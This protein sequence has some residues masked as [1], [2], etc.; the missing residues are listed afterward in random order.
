MTYTYYNKKSGRAGAFFCL[1][2]SLVMTI[3]ALAAPMQAAA[4][5]AQPAAIDGSAAILV[6][7]RTGTVLY[8][9]NADSQIVPASTT[10]VMT[11]LLVVEAIQRGEIALT[12]LVA[13]TDEIM[14]DVPSDA[15]RIGNA[16]VVGEQVP[17]RDLLYMALMESDCVACDMLAVHVS[18]SVQAFVDQM[19]VRASQL[20]CANTNFL[21][22]HGYPKEG[23]TSTAR[24][25]YL[26]TAEAVKYPLF[27]E[28]FGCLKYVVP[29][30]NMAASRTIYSTDKLLYDP[31]VVTSMYTVYYNEYVTGG[32]TGYSTASGNCLVS[33]AEKDGLQL[34][35]V[36]TGVKMK[37]PDEQT[38]IDAF[39]ESDRLIRWGLENYSSYRAVAAGEPVKNVIEVEKGTPQ[40]IS[41]VCSDNI[42]VTLEKGEPA[43]SVQVTSTLVG[44]V[45]QAPVSSGDVIGSVS[46]MKNGKTLAS[47]DLVAGGD[48]AIAPKVFK[49]NVPL[50]LILSMI[51]AA[52]A[53]FLVYYTNRNE[54]LLVD[55]A[56]EK[57]GLSNG[58][59]T[60]GSTPRRVQK[61]APRPVEEEAENDPYAGLFSGMDYDE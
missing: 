46:V 61:P 17:V 13:L 43:E 26:I 19:N 48:S 51:V 28:A 35:S 12:D 2:L 30:T 40:T 47:A 3:C 38:V 42:Y 15:S 1:L 52:G 36:I 60:S 10:K 23:H 32:K 14:H 5:V 39:T 56:K 41:G 50:I 54:L 53:A 7:A 9:Q 49:A 18:G 45:L 33:T 27:T 55:Y 11:A 29:E 21:N 8:E 58:T 16:M 34:I 44:E 6:D 57:L 22:S 24:S 20:G 37:Y 4:A 59:K 31:A 25:L